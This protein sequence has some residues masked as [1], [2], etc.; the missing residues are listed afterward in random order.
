MGRNTRKTLLLL[1]AI[2]LMVAACRRDPA[3]V[4]APGTPGTGV[5]PDLAAMPYDSLSTYGFFVGNMADQVPAEGLLPYAPITPLYSDGAHKIRFVWMPASTSASYVS[6]GEVLDFPEGT[7]LIKTFHFDRVLPADARRIV[8]TR[9]LFRRNGEWHFADYVW[10]EAQTEAVL[11]LSGSVTPI[12]HIDE[13]GQTRQVNYRIPAQAE[14]WTCH[15]SNN[16][17]A[18]IGPK[19]RNL[20][21]LH[22]Y[23]DGVR[24]QLA[25]WEA[26]GY[27]D[28]AHPPVTTT[29]ARW[30]DPS[31]DMEERVRA[32]LDINC[33]HCHTDGGHCDY[34]PMRFSWED[35][36][37]PVN[38]GRCVAPHDPIFP[39][40]TYIIAAGDP[41]ASMAYRRMNTTLE[42]QRM[43]LLGRTTIHEEGVQLM[44]QWINNLG[45]P[46]P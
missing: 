3:E 4:V 2:G 24:D 17:P 26:V 42:N 12:E 22:A 7:I 16:I 45:P 39:D 43:P 27:L 29:V 15:K 10:N 13:N 25:E 31:A 37:D 44:E 40:A 38:L 23:A 20:N 28:P 33:A 5:D 32:Y 36:A 46:C 8:E 6:D 19:P 34:R 14:C 18:P 41:Q 30:D 1:A 11:D 21:T 9:L 35:T